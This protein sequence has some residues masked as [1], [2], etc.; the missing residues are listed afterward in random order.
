[1]VDAAIGQLGP[2]L[3]GS[4]TRFTVSSRMHSTRD[5]VSQEEPRGVGKTVG[6]VGDRGQKRTFLSNQTRFFREYT[7]GKFISRN[8]Q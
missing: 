7:I 8:R 3:A 5:A 4:S 1:M 6:W 2:V